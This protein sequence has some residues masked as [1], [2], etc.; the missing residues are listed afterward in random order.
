MRVCVPHIA[1]LCVSM[2]F[3]LRMCSQGS[4]SMKTSFNDGNCIILFV[5]CLYV[6]FTG[7]CKGSNKCQQRAKLYRRVTAAIIMNNTI[8]SNV[9]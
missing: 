1:S 9:P 5:H 3:Y 6:L 8:K 7:R 2:H 4:A